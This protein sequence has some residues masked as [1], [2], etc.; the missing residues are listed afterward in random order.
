MTSTTASV[1]SCS[2]KRCTV[3][4]NAQDSSCDAQNNQ[5]AYAFQYGDGSGASGY[6]VSDVLH[7][8]TAGGNQSVT[9][10]SSASIVFG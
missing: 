1:V 8:D 7:F 5:C 4:F 2:D 10:N 9:S 6:Y 3:G